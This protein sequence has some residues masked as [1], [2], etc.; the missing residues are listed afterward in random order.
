VIPRYD[1]RAWSS[2][3]PHGNDDLGPGV[4]GLVEAERVAV[5]VA[6]HEVDRS[7]SLDG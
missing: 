3:T 1:L 5:E 7:C 4:M 2:S 6:S